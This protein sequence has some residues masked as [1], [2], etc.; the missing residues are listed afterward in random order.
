MALAFGNDAG[1]QTF[2]KPAL[3][4]LKKENIKVVSNQTL[5]INSTTFET[6]AQAIVSAHPDAIVMETLGAAGVA[7]IDESIS[8]TATR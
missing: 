5:D 2:V 3:A 6:E 1:S 4:A 8:S 7:L